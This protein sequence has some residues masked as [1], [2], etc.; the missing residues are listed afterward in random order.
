MIAKIPNPILP[1]RR[2]ESPITNTTTETPSYLIRSYSFIQKRDGDTPPRASSRDIIIP[3]IVI[4]VFLVL[5]TYGI[6]RLVHVARSSSI[7]TT[8]STSSSGSSEG[9]FIMQEVWVESTIKTLCRLVTLS[10]FLQRASFESNGENIY[11][12]RQQ[13]ESLKGYTNWRSGVLFYPYKAKEFQ[14][15]KYDVVQWRLSRRKPKS[16]PP[17]VMEK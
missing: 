11:R 16:L 17:Q 4:F 15:A 3:I 10:R 12:R 5:T 1:S 7:S 14:A 9:H 6:Y 13:D 8:S 2:V